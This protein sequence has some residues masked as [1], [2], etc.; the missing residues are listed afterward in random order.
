MYKTI[1][2]NTVNKPIIKMDLP[3]GTV[4]IECYPD[5]A[6]KHVA[7]ILSQAEQGMYDGTV[8]HRVIQGFM[9]QGGWTQKSLPQL[10]AEFNDV[11]HVEGICSMARTNDPN[12]ASDQFFICFGDARFLDN[13]YTVWGKVIYG[14]NHV[15]NGIS[16]GEPPAEPTP[17]IRMRPVDLSSYA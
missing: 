13:N 16:K 7:Q 14:M 4:L 5:K 6:P 3:S 15:H 17:I 8:F 2:E 9:A 12:S 1:Q 11:P 10:E